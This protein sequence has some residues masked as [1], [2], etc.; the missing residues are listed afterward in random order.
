M[1]PPVSA[2]LHTNYWTDWGRASAQ[3]RPSTFIVWIL[4]LWPKMHFVNSHPPDEDLCKRTHFASFWPIV[5]MDPVN[6]LLTL[7]HLITTKTTTMADNILVFVL[8]KIL[9]LL[10]LLGQNIL[11]LC[12][13]AER[14]RITDKRLTVFVFFLCSVS[15]YCLFVYSVQALCTCSVSSSPFLVNFMHHL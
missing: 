12:R 2:G 1:F 8:Q 7:R 13:Y 15:F 10:W 6:A 3:N 9:S 5:H 11:L 4:A 14:K